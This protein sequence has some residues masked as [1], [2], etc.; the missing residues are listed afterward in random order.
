MKAFQMVDN[1][2]D[3]KTD[4]KGEFTEESQY[5]HFKKSKVFDGFVEVFSG[6]K[7]L[8]FVVIFSISIEACQAFKDKALNSKLLTSLNLKKSES[9]SKGF[10]VLE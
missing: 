1:F 9:N 7:P 3:L 4:S 8:Y 6:K 10:E 5:Q 2:D